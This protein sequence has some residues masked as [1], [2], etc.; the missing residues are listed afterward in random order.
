MNDKPKPPTPPKPPQPPQQLS[1]AARY[2]AGNLD[3][4][5]LERKAGVP[6]AIDP[7]A[8]AAEIEFARTPDLR[9]AVDWIAGSAEK[10]QWAI[11]LGAGLGANSFAMA[12]DGLTMIAVDTSPARLRALRERARAVG[13]EHKI[14][15]VAAAAEALPFRDGCVP[16]IYTKSV[17]IHTDLPR[18]AREFARIVCPGGRLALV[19][20]QPGNPFVEL[21]RRTLAPRAWRTITHYF[22]RDS[23]RAFTAS[24]GLRAGSQSAA[25]FYFLS[26]FAFVFEYAIPIPALFRPALRVLGWVDAALFRLCPPLRRTAWFCVLR[27]EREYKKE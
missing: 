6:E 5:N 3:P 26:F 19:E 27:L 14:R 20:P 18:V 24:P 10:P 9:C 17:L 12:A 4:Q 7:V 23:Q 16:A 15:I 13:L 2:W 11:D 1:E 22:D 21:Y 25:Y 8:V